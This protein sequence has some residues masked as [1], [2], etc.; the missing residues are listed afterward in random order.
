MVNPQCGKRNGKC[1]MGN[2]QWE[3]RNG[4][5]A[6]RNE[7]FPETRLPSCLLLIFA[8]VSPFAS[9]APKSRTLVVSETFASYSLFFAHSFR[10]RALCVLQTTIRKSRRSFPN[11]TR[12]P[13]IRTSRFYRF[14]LSVSKVS[15]RMKAFPSFESFPAT[16]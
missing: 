15:S 11:F 9:F 10:P 5:S 6:K 8:Q 1:A 2:A 14:E 13:P 3:M 16:V 7:A 12:R 4:E